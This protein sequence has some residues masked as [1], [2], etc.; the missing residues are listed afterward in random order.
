MI[1]LLLVL[2]ACSS[3]REQQQ[4]AV[5]QKKL[6]AAEKK[7][8]KLQDEVK[9]ISF[10]LNAV[11]LSFIRKQLDD[12]EKQKDKT[13]RLFLEEREALY[14]IIQTAPPPYAAEAQVE[15]DRILRLITEQSD[16]G[17]HV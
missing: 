1:F 15:L 7:E 13:V 14:R 5:L 12:Y 11:Q 6:G 17:T 4:I 16:Q 9:K 3:A 2:S 8:R 10:E